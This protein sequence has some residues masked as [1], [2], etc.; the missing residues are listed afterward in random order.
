MMI[1]GSAS[2]FKNR[3]SKESFFPSSRR[4]LPN[5]LSLF[6][7]SCELK[8]SAEDFCSFN[9]SS[10]LSRYSFTFPPIRTFS[11]LVF[12]CFRLPHPSF[13]RARRPHIFY[14]IIYYP[15]CPTSASLYA[16]EKC[17]YSVLHILSSLSKRKKNFAC[18]ILRA[19][20]GCKAAISSPR[21]A[22]PCTKCILFHG[23][24]LFLLCFHT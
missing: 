1:I 13:V 21:A 4:F 16:Y 20:A 5:S 14:H 17:R 23:K 15:F 7:A 22:H 2:S 6:S 9:T 3:F 8:P 11:R 10:K 12:S 24:D 18:E 19:R